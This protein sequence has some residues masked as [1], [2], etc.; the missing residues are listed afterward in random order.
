MSFKI[1]TCNYYIFISLAKITISLENPNKKGE[2][3]V[4]V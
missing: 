2:K 3:I 1:Q 4:A